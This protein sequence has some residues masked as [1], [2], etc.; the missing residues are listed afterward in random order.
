MQFL[1]CFFYKLPIQIRDDHSSMQQLFYRALYVRLIEI[2]RQ[3]DR[4][5]VCQ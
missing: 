5:M 1:R 2:D 4:Q 3:T